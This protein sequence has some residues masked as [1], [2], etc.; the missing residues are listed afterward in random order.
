MRQGLLACHAGGQAIRVGRRHAEHVEQQRPEHGVELLDPADAHAAQRVAVIGLAQGQV[1]RLLRPRVAALPPV[2]QGHFEGHFDRRGA[3]V[4]EEHVVQARR[5]E[6]D[7]PL[8]QPDRRRIRRPSDVTWAT[9]SS[10]S[11]M[12][13]SIFGWRCPW[14]LHHRLLTPSRY[15]RPSMSTSV[16][17]SARSMMSGSYSPICVKACQTISRSQRTDHRA[18]A[19][20]GR[21]R[22]PAS[23]LR[24]QPAVCWSPVA[25]SVCACLASRPAGATS[26]AHRGADGH[27]QHDSGAVAHDGQLELSA[28]ARAAR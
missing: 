17:P 3:V 13:A 6:L 26:H 25:R 23:R 10:W 16:Q 8:G 20:Q 2:L 21:A 12:A 11:R 27:P 22:S 15:S 14:T 24:H 4:G 7:Q 28:G 9:W 19:G 1:G 5:R 18:R